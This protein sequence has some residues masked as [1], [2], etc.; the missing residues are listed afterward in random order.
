[1]E[2]KIFTIRI[3]IV[4]HK[5]TQHLAKQEHRSLNKQI[6]YLL[7]QAIQLPEN[8]EKLIQLQQ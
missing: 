7:E 5:H 1:M 2:R 8:R 6:V 4:L 3:P